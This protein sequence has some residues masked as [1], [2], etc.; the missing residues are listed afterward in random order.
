L[1][2]NM[3]M[4]LMIWYDKFYRPLPGR[5]YW[6]LCLPGNLIIWC[7]WCL[8]SVSLTLSVLRPLAAI[9]LRHFSGNFTRILIY[10]MKNW[11]GL[12]YFFSLL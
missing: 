3:L 10:A 9:V 2:H 8:W 5:K 12:W 1:G 7:Q 4:D 11:K 6:L